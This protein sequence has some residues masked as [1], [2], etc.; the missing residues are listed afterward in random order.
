MDSKHRAHCG[1][2]TPS[3]SGKPQ[4]AHTL[5][6]RAT[7][8]AIARAGANQ[9]KKINFFVFACKGKG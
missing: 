7:E 8:L 3:G 5:A 1:N 9:F 6:R 4:L 2:V